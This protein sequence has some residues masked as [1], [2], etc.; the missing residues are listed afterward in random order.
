MHRGTPRASGLQ[1]RH[2]IALASLVLLTVAAWAIWSYRADG[3]LRVLLATPT[4]GGSR[5]EAVRAYVLGWGALAPLV[6]IMSVMMEVLIAPIPGTLLYAPAGAIFGGFWGGTLS[7]CGN[8]LGAA[9][10]CWLAGSLGERWR[11]THR[12]SPQFARIQARLTRRD[13]WVIVFLL[14]L[15]PLTSSDLVSYAAGVADVRVRH[16]ALGTFLGM[17]PQCY[18]Q[19]YLA[20]T[21]FEA[22]T[23]GTWVLVGVGVLTAAV[24]LALWRLFFGPSRQ[25]VDKAL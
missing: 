23:S 11:E 1:T 13:A 24:A 17:L 20:Q 19:A 4:D 12:Q 7:L 21:L 14:R 5:L 16:V 2:K 8:V 25:P 18:L 22:L 9:T 15:N 3:L 10:A 6:Y